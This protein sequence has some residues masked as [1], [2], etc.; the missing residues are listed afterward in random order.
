MNY[1]GRQLCLSTPVSQFHVCAIS[2]VTSKN[3][4]IGTKTSPLSMHD[5]GQPREATSYPKPCAGRESMP[6]REATQHSSPMAVSH[7]PCESP[8][9]NPPRFHLKTPRLLIGTSVS[10][11]HGPELSGEPRCSM[12]R[13]TAT[14]ASLPHQA[15]K[16]QAQTST[17]VSPWILNVGA[18]T[19]FISFESAVRHNAPACSCERRSVAQ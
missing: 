3:V 6:M 18:K 1:A 19:A 10:Q 8:D 16:L 2:L 15:Q 7:V 13:S 12:I 4:W 11:S 14:E 5:A 17:D 9:D